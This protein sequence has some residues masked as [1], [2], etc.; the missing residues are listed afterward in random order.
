MNCCRLDL[1]RSSV[2]SFGA[3]RR[4]RFSHRLV[5]HQLPEV[6][7]QD[8]LGESHKHTK[9]KHLAVQPEGKTRNSWAPWTDLLLEMSGSTETRP[10]G[11]TQSPHPPIAGTL[12]SDTISNE[13][14]QASGWRAFHRLQSTFA[15]GTGPSA[16]HL[17]VVRREAPCLH[18]CPPILWNIP[19]LRE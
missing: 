12:P 16:C 11:T 9:E 18:S 19:A 14:T 6:F 1:G 2:D 8:A 5:V 3:W 17:R 4:V 15:L 13:A 7:S 10:V